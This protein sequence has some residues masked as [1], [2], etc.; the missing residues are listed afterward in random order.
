MGEKKEKERKKTPS[1]KSTGG[2]GE[3]RGCGRGGCLAKCK[4]NIITGLGQ[5]KKRTNTLKARHG[6]PCNS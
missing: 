1:I 3:G 5:Y 6:H 2:K 4:N